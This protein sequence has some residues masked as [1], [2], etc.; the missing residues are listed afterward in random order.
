MKSE[1][2]AHGALKHSDYRP[3]F[4]EERIAES[5]EDFG[6][7]C[8]QGVKYCGKTW[9]AQAFANSETNLMDPAGNFQSL[10]IARMAPQ[11]ALQGESPRLIDEWQEAP[12]LWDGVRNEID[13]SGKRRTFLLTGSAVPR[14][15]KPK[16]SGVGRIEKLAMRTM[17]LAE[18]GASSG[19][20][21]L[22]ALFKGKIPQAAAPET[23]LEDIID[24]VVRGGWPSLID[25]PAKRAQRVARSYVGEIQR[26]DLSRVDG[27]KRD[28]EKI[29]RLMHS[30]ARNAEQATKTK[31]I[32]GDM[33][34]QDEEKPLSPETVT[35][36]LEALKKIFVV[37]EIAPWAPN[38]RSPVRINKRPKYHYADPSIPAAILKATPETLMGD[39]ETLGFLFECLC[40]R[41]LLVYAQAMDAEVFYYRDKSSLEADAIIQ[42]PSGAWAAIEIKLG[43]NKADEAA[44]NLL[45]LRDKI[46]AA[47]GTEPA[48]LM[49][50]EGLGAYAFQREDG[51]FVAPIRTL[52]R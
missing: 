21:S 27:V 7:A 30:L 14:E 15:E 11:M 43:H 18:A 23:S 31:T 12:Q 44:A 20:V 17:S 5:L 38:L 22:A 40:I 36:Y 10:E 29:A 47:G 51:V 16:H 46:T 28:P 24:L 42:A 52:T 3:R 41:D 32:I 45:A 19:A 49:A 1:N 9:T 2:L 6:A 37:E 26:D 4:I 35:D 48:F 34:A 8:I 50:V 33:T 39:L 25:V 13:R